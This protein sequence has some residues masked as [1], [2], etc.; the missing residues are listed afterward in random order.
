MVHAEVD[1]QPSASARLFG[2]WSRDGCQMRHNSSFGC[3][4]HYDTA[5]P[6]D[7]WCREVPLEGC[8]HA[9]ALPARVPRGRDPGRRC[10]RHRYPDWIVSP[11]GHEITASMGCSGCPACGPPAYR[12][13]RAQ[14]P[15]RSPSPDGGASQHQC[16]SSRSDSGECCSQEA[17]HRDLH[18]HRLCALVGDRTHATTYHHLLLAPQIRDIV[19]K[20]RRCPRPG[21]GRTDDTHARE[22]IDC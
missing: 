2:C 3:L 20:S 14:L 18:A 17:E 22:A 11:R 5:N 6:P 4:D 1:R 21:R 19:T 15:S 8:D 16:S 12:Q 7:V 10:R 9:R 13:G